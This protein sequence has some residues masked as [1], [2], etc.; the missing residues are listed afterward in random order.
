MTS[1]PR[2][3]A[4]AC[5][6]ALLTA[7][8]LSVGAASICVCVLGCDLM[9]HVANDAGAHSRCGAALALASWRLQ[10]CRMREGLDSCTA[11]PGSVADACGK[12]RLPSGCGMLLRTLR[13]QSHH[14]VQ[15]F[16]GG[17]YAKSGAREEQLARVADSPSAPWS[18]GQN[19]SFRW[20]SGCADGMRDSALSSC[21]CV[22]R[23]TT[24]ASV[25]V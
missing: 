11:H 24:R 22:S 6:C 23:P 17:E 18:T 3:T 2:P 4:A 19:W 9:S 16:A 13:W 5:R 14:P 10:P 21:Q 20:L 1:C 7:G 8:V 25:K 15:N 12:E